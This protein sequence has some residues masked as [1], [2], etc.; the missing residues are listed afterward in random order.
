MGTYRFKRM[1]GG[2]IAQSL[3]VTGKELC[4]AGG[5]TAH[6][7]QLMA[8]VCCR[9]WARLLRHAP[10][11]VWPHESSS[12]SRRRLPLSGHETIQFV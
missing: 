8:L 11:K 2:G 3:V 5:L 1:D 7:G 12:G 6:W 9:M 10:Q 4:S